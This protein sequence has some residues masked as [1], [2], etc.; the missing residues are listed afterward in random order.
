MPVTATTR[1]LGS[2]PAAAQLIDAVERRTGI[3]LSVADE[4]PAEIELFVDPNSSAPEGYTLEIG[5]R[6]V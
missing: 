4:A 6:A 3:R 5:E 1:V 2:S